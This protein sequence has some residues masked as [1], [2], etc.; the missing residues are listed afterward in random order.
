VPEFAEELGSAPHMKNIIFIIRPKDD[1]HL[2]TKVSR[3]K[4]LP[5]ILYMH[6]YMSIFPLRGFID[7]IKLDIVD[8]NS[9]NK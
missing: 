3:K 7:N 5:S 4:S 9:S 1:S 8:I 6:E 2:S